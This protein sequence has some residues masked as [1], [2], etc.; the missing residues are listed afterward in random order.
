MGLAVLVPSSLTAEAED[1]RIAT[2]KVGVVARAAAIYRCDTVVVYDDEPHDDAVALVLRYMATPPYLR[3]EVYDV[4]PEL[5]YVG[6]V[7]PLRI[8]PHTV[9]SEGNAFEPYREGVVTRV[10]SDGRVWVNC[11]MQ[12]PVALRVPDQGIREGERVTLRISSRE[13]LRAEVVPPDEVPHYTGYRVMEAGLTDWLATHDGA[14]VMASREGEPVRPEHLAGD[15]VALVFGSPDR[16]VQEILRTQ[17]DA[18]PEFDAAV[19]TIPSQG[20]ETVRTEEAVHATLAVR[21]A[22]R[23]Q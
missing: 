23:S 18:S 17:Y 13:P 15:D 5:R 22:F 11:G 4:R 6:V 10:G 20:V 1:R 12:H 9:G 2:Y 16:G 7:S 8:P 3:K 21:N 14:T 19:N